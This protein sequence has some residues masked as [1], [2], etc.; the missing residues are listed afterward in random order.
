M[1]MLLIAGI[2]FGCGG[3]TTDADT[4]AAEETPATTDA[5]PAPAAT[6]LD[7]NLASE[8]DLLALP[9]IDAALA[10][11]IVDG[12]P[13]LNMTDFRQV[14]AGTLSESEL[15]AVFTGL[16]VPLNL[17]TAP[18]EEFLLI[19]GVGDRMVHEFEEYRPYQSMEQFR[20]EIGK[21]VD[22]DELARLERYVYLDAEN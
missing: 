17:N 22:E 18:E 10:R 19:P 12:R 20:R 1:L 21:Y 15:E 3:E 11:R 9:G 14:L 5:D 16:F 2:A 13:Y 4:A 7:P 8:S 6:V